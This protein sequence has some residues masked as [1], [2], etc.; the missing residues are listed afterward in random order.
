[1]QRIGRTSPHRV[2]ALI[3]DAAQRQGLVAIR[4]LGR[5]GLAS[6]AV[7]SDR[8]A[9][10]FTSRWCAASAVVPDFASDQDAFVEALL[11]LCAVHRPRALIPVHD[12]S[13]EALRP[14]REDLER[15]VGL[16]LGPEDALEVAVDKARTLA[17]AQAV[18]LRAHVEFL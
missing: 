10:A 1:M 12:G 13:V 5:A 3:T 17:Q 11:E 14:R 4:D 9:P 2:D 8:H 15:V 7:N 16:A 6:C 18:G